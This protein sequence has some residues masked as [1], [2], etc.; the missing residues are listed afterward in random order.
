VRRTLLPSAALAL[1]AAIPAQSTL[2]VGPA[3]FPTVQAAIDAASAGD[4]IV[5]QPGSY[6]SFTTSKGVTIRAEVPGTVD[7]AGGGFFALITAPPSEPMRLQGLR[8]GSYNM[9]NGRITIEDCSFTSAGVVLGL[10][11]ATAHL[12]RVTIDGQPFLIGAQAALVVNDSVVTMNDCTITPE[13]GGPG[14]SGTPGIDVNNATLLASNSTISGAL[15]PTALPALQLDAL[16]TARL[17]DCTIV[18]GANSCGVVGGD[19]VCSRCTLPASCALPTTTL[20]GARANGNVVR[21]QTYSVT[22]TGAP[23]EFLLVFGSN[24]ID[25]TV[26]ATLQQPF[27]LDEVG[28]FPAAALLTDANG[29]ATLDVPVPNMLV[30]P[31]IGVYLQGVSGSAFPLLTSPLVGGV[32]L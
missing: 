30:P 32:I 24:E 8:L 21:G 2:T 10:S 12:E 9:L 28:C 16:S 20:L 19:V 7:I 22:F 3:G 6:A 26:A 25:A 23:N 4:E 18:A 11:F 14:S 27:L 29:A 31:G 17:T 5:V 13:P 1:A 15:G